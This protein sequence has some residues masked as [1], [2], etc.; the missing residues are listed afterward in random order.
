MLSCTETTYMGCGNIFTM[1]RR[2]SVWPGRVFQCVGPPPVTVITF[3]LVSTLPGCPW[4][5]WGTLPCSTA[6]PVVSLTPPTPGTA[7]SQHLKLAWIFI[8]ASTFKHFHLW[9]SSCSGIPR[10][11][12]LPSSLVGNVENLNILHFIWLLFYQ[13]DKIQMVLDRVEVAL[14][15]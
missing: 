6:T 15:S 2:V 11:L 5:R 4:V 1:W 9:F 12:D 10:M 7:S 8:S 3:C 14:L 13:R